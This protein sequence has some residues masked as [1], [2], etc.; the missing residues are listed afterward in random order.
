MRF[1]LCG[2]VLLVGAGVVSLRAQPPAWVTLKGQ[3]VLPKGVDIPA[4]KPIAVG[5][6]CPLGPK[7]NKNAVLDDTLIINPTNR[8]IKNV[9]VWLRPNNMNPKAAFAAKEIHPADAKRKP[10]HLV[11]DQPCCMFEPHVLAARAGD[12]L[13]VKNSAAVNHNFFWESANNGA[14]NVNIPGKG[15]HKFPNPLAAEPSAIPFRCTIH[16]WMSGWVRVFDHP[17]FAVTDEDGKFEIKDAPAGNYRVVYWHE[18]V[19]FL[20]GKAGRF[21]TPVVIAGGKDNTM[22]MKPTDF[23]VTK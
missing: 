18:K 17:Y 21:G 23:D 7:C 22:E 9:V 10:Q 19:G 6:N 4:R 3:V 2:L 5:Q 15:Q 12:T 13:A 16:P 20:G 14:V 1:V 8:G 11:I